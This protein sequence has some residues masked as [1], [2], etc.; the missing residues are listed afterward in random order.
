[1]LEMDISYDLNMKNKLYSLTFSEVLPH[2]NLKFSDDAARVSA[3]NTFIRII[4][5]FK[6]NNFLETIGVRFSWQFISSL[7]QELSNNNYLVLNL[8]SIIDEILHLESPDIFST[9]TKE[10]T[11]FKSEN[12]KKIYHKH[13]ISD[14]SSTLMGYSN[15]GVLHKYIRD[16]VEISSKIIRFKHLDRCDLL[17]YN[18]VTKELINRFFITQLILSKSALTKIAKKKATGEW[19]IYSKPDD[20][21]YYLSLWKHCNDLEPIKKLIT[22]SISPM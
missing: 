20:K 12:L 16:E 18:E 13:Y 2:L 7:I 4:D 19:I 8:H 15:N 22:N 9:N 21:N 10:A 14:T 6:K 11:T 1:M 17:G 5:I 3:E